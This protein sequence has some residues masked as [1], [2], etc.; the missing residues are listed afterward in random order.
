MQAKHLL[1]P[2]LLAVGVVAAFPQ[3]L[4]AQGPALTLAVAY[5]PGLDVTRY[6]VAEKFD[7]MR[8]YWDGRQL[9]SRAGTPIQAPAWFTQDLPNIP[10]EG[11]LWLGRGKFQQLMSIVRDQVPDDGQW[12]KVTWQLFDMPGYPGSYWHR[13]Q[14]LAS[15]VSR[16]DKA[17]LKSVVIE[18]VATE[19]A[20]RQKLA[21]IEALGGEGVMLYR[22][23]A[24][25]RAG[26]GGALV[27]LKSYQDDEAR[28]V[29]YLPGKGK[30]KGMMGSL[31]VED[32]QG[33]RFKLGTGFSDAER[34]Q[35]PEIG[36][37]VNYR[38]NGRTDAGLPRF[39]RYQGRFLGF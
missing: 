11:E 30:F 17:H 8:A 29:A 12:R 4:Y 16:L 26:R 39:A 37:V 38:Y 31:L 18:R 28:V 20:L 21:R 23:E 7:G 6:G 13:H 9:L 35:P 25:Y 3:Q 22:L 33:R 27:K 36:S 24:P 19:Q 15:L 34:Q 10:L 2:S 32:A 14:A 5:Q 1:I